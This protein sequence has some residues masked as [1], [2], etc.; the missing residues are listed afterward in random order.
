MAT[1]EQIQA[2]LGCKRLAVVGVS[3][4]RND[5]SRI[6]FREFLKRGYDAVPVHPAAGEVDGKQCF[7]HLSDISP[8]VEAALL[9]TSPS[10]T[11]QVV[12][13][14]DAAGVRRVWMH[15][16][17]GCGAVNETAATWCQS[18]GIDV[19]AGECPLMFLPQTALPHRI[20]GLLRRITGRY[21]RS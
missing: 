9:L 21:P 16:G 12:E 19:I 20:H 4:N 11:A 1:R 18:H 6:L 10:V 13:D 3:R 17:A 15:R 8:A 2:F 14:C 5:F 7:P